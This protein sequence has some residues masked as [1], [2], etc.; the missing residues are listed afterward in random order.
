VLGICGGMQMLGDRIDDPYGI[1]STSGTSRGLGWLEVVTTLEPHKQLRRVRGTLAFGIRSNRAAAVSGY[2]I[3]AGETTGAGLARPL[4]ELDDRVDGAFSA[5][6]KIAGT[7]LHC[8]RRTAELG[9][10]ER[11][12]SLRLHCASRSR[13]RASC[14]LCH[15]TAR[16]RRHRRTHSL[17]RQLSNRQ[18]HPFFDQH[19]VPVKKPSTSFRLVPKKYL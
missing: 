4:V 16:F 11:G 15:K 13:H 1:E 17:A 7:Y 10:T 6:G 9:R 8:L 5:D 2:E 12:A 14:E 19:M 18:I 3:H